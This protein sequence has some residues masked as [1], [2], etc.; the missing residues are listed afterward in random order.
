MPQ[1]R[2]LRQPSLQ[3]VGSA[4][5]RDIDLIT[6]ARLGVKVTSRL[7]DLSGQC[8]RFSDT[9]AADMLAAEQRRLRTLSRID[10]FI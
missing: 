7:A 4:P 3:L 5:P 8:A 1:A 10:G 2:A 6:L 9:L